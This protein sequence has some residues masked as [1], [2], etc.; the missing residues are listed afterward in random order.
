MGNTLTHRGD[1]STL[2]PAASLD[3]DLRA[4]IPEHRWDILTLL[5]DQAAA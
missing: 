5:G 1:H 2:S 4:A 3:D